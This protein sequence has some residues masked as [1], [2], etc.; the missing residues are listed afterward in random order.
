MLESKKLKLLSKDEASLPFMGKKN[1]KDIS[2]LTG[3]LNLDKKQTPHINPVDISKQIYI[4]KLGSE[5]ITNPKYLSYKENVRQKILNQAY[6]Y[7]DHPDFDSAEISLAF[8]MNSQGALKEV[9]II[10]DKSKGSEFMKNIALR[11]IKEAAP[12]G[13]FPPDLNYPEL[14]YNITIVFEVKK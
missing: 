2:K 4:P 9:K 1:I 14:P 11:C 6:R 8:V 10:S 3:K 13:I 7:I 5:K 12:Y